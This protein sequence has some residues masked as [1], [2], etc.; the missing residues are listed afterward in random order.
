[1]CKVF[2]F[3]FFFIGFYG[4]FR[5]IAATTTYLHLSLFW[6]NFSP[7]LTPK[8]DASFVILSFHRSLDHPLGFLVPSFQLVANLIGSLD[9]HTCSAHQS[10]LLLRSPIIFAS[11][12][13]TSTSRFVL[14][15]NYPEVFRFGPNILLRIFRSKVA[16]LFSLSFSLVF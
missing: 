1:L 3:F 13:S 5:S 9:L 7:L 16:S 6:A 12:Y 4:P 8:I 10:L 15:S 11:P 14:I 2:L